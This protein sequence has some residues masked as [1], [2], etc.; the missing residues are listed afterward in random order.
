VNDS[1]FELGSPVRA[2]AD[3]YAGYTGFPT[4]P[5]H[6]EIQYRIQGYELPTNG[7]ESWSLEVASIDKGVVEGGQR[8]WDEENDAKSWAPLPTTY[9]WQGRL[10]VIGSRLA[11]FDISEPLKPRLIS[12]VPFGYS[13]HYLDLAGVD[14]FPLNLPPVV[15]LPPQQRAEVAVKRHWGWESSGLEGDIFCAWSLNI[16]TL[17]EYRLTKLSDSVAVFKKVGQYQTT[18]LDR[19]FGFYGYYDM[20]MLNGLLYMSQGGNGGPFNPAITVFETRGEPPLRIVGHFAAP[21]IQ[22]VCPLPDGRALVGGSKLWLVGPPQRH[23]SD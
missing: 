21:G 22:T 6:P 20:K 8:L 3:F 19:V 13:D 15:D 11:M 1:G 17:C 5:G 23:G 7:N 9:V 2:I 12:E 4:P 10:Y 16:N 14:E 18:M